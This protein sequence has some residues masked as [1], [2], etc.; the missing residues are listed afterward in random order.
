MLPQCCHVATAREASGDPP[1]LDTRSDGVRFPLRAEAPLLRDPSENTL[2]VL[3]PPLVRIVAPL[4]PYVP[5]CDTLKQGVRR[6][7]GNCTPAWL[8]RI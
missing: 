7:A 4:R 3:D 2:L 6:S 1:S 8:N 5:R